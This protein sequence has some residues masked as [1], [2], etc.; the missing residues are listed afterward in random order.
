MN[1][2]LLL[3]LMFFVAAGASAQEPALNEADT[4][5]IHH[6]LRELRQAMLDAY[7]SRDVDGIVK[8][9]EE[10]VVITWQNGDRN[11]SHEEFLA[12]YNEML[13]GD[14]RIVKEMSSDFVVDGD[15]LIHSDDTAVAYGTCTDHFE[16]TNGSEFDL[17]SKWTATVVK[18]EQ[19]WKIASFHMSANI[20]ENPILSYAQSWLIKAGVIGGLVGAVLGFVLAFLLRR[21]PV[22]AKSHSEDLTSNE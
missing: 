22:T 15:S 2:T 5:Q 11:L 14:A 17:T 9:V 13:N 19:G 18:K 10:D 4:Q 1:R 3:V 6:E 16:L 12:F 8:H 7:E 20:F 21:R